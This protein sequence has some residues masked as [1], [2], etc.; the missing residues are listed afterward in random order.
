MTVLLREALAS[1]PHRFSRFALIAVLA[2]LT[3]C[4]PSS[5]PSDQLLLPGLTPVSE[6]DLPATVRVASHDGVEVDPRQRH[7]LQTSNSQREAVLTVDGLSWRTRVATR[8]QPILQVNAAAQGAESSSGEIVVETG[9]REIYRAAVG[10]G[11]WQLH[12]I[13]LEDQGD[14]ELVL[15]SDGETPIA[16]ADLVLTWPTPDR[17]PNLILISIDTLR[18]DHLT[19]YGYERQTSPNLDRLAEK[20]FLF[21]RSYST[22]TWTL[23]STATLLTGLLPAQHNV[24]RRRDSLGDLPTLAKTL[25]DAGYR[26]VGFVDGGYLGFGWGLSLGFQS[27][28]SGADDRARTDDVA[29]VVERASNWLRGNR[30]EPFFLFLQTYETHQPHRNREGFA[31]PFLDSLQDGLRFES[32]SPLKLLASGEDDPAV[33]RRVEALYDG[34]IARTDHYLGQLFDVLRGLDVFDN[35]AIVITS[36]HGEEFLEHGGVDHYAAKVFDENIR[37]PLILRLPGQT[38]GEVVATPVT[39]ADVVPTF[40]DLAGLEPSS[41]LVGRSL[42]SLPEDR[43]RTVVMHGLSTARGRGQERF[44]LDSGSQSLIL[45]RRKGL[46]RLYDRDQDPGMRQPLPSVDGPLV[47]RLQSLLAWMSKRGQAFVRLP[48]GTELLQIPAESAIQ[49]ISVWQD[50]ER[51]RIYREEREIEL[52][53]RAAALV[54]EIGSEGDLALR[55]RSRGGELRRWVLKVEP[56]EG[57]WSPMLELPEVLRAF[58]TAQSRESAAAEIDDESLRQLRALGYL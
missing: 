49:P 17:R 10:A 6:E 37:V 43:D 38:D 40:L 29:A 55:L 13:Q 16:W 32:A 39:G 22:S 4:E 52:D 30:F 50:L 48:P 54:F 44:R 24:R 42:L 51:R 18:A 58:A 35:T 25:S 1:H 33:W 47:L 2:T 53:G 8:D 36:D 28:T 21:T 31:D 26:T 27:Y 41:E 20:S 34:E 15:S 45:E 7:L 9:G 14:V 19:C 57:G 12:E 11:S 56:P 46:V 23:P 5:I 3:A